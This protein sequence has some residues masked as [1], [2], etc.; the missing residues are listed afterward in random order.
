MKIRTVLAA[1]AGI[2]IG[3][4]LGT[5]AGRARFE[6]IKSQAERVLKDP[7][8]R[9]KVHD[10][11]EQVRENLPKAQAV[12]TDAIKVAS[13]KVQAATTERREPGPNPQS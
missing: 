3:Y 9:Q 8:V 5:K 2:G 12:V 13:E 10:I 1:A 4:V 6:E 11:P 7:E